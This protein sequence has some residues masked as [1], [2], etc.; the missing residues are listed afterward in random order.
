MHSA[1]VRLAALLFV[2][3]IG[4]F[5]H[6]P[7]AAAQQSQATLTVAGRTVRCGN[8]RNVLDARLPNLGM[9]APG[10]VVLNP[11][12]LQRQP[13]IV[14]LFVYHHECGHHHVGGDEVAADCWAA[15]Q[16]AR[17]GWLGKAGIEQ[18]C[19]SFGN[20][21]ATTTHP[22]GPSRCASLRRCFAD[23]TGTG[24][25]AAATKG[26]AA[27]KVVSRPKAGRSSLGAPAE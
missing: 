25:A 10:V 20:R 9:A 12:M 26:N 14:R 22:S 16:G 3:G 8:L 7:P 15:R 6:A 17:Q 2:A 4:T 21:P 13:A 27:A 11:V 24:T 1:N 19:R 5:A 18:V 23:I